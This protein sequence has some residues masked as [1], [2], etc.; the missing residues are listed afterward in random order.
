[1]VSPGEQHRA[2]FTITVAGSHEETVGD[3]RDDG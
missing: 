2:T 1:V 3:Q